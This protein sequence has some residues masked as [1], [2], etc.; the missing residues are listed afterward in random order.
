MVSRRLVHPALNSNSP[1]FHWMVCKINT[2]R[3]ELQVEVSDYVL[4]T[5]QVH[6]KCRV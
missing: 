2:I 1:V 4:G 5:G 3:G 6:P